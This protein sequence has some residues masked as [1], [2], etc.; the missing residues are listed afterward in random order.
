MMIQLVSYHGEIVILN[1]DFMVSIVGDGQIKNTGDGWYC[2][3]VAMSDGKTYCVR[4]TPKQISDLQR[5]D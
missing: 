3:V 5:R 2:S 1:T 4:E